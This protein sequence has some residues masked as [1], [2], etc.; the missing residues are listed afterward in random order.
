[1]KIDHIAI[2]VERLED[3]IK[4]YENLPGISFLDAGEM[5][6]EGVRIANFRAGGISLEF[7]EPLGKES[8]VARFI[9]KKGPGIH[10][11]A[12]EVNNL[13]EW[14]R[15]LKAAGVRLV[16]ETPR[17]GWGGRQIVFLHPSSVGG[18]LIELLRKSRETSQQENGTTNASIQ[19][20]L[21]LRRFC[22]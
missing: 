18:V 2:A 8:P 9:E 16:N 7:L 1:M 14:V 4:A 5:V 12:F 15:V 19:G 13:E 6:S 10:H 11:I 22:V 20:L 3:I 21:F 17:N